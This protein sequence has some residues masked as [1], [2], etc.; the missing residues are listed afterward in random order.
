MTLLF[1]V[2]TIHVPKLNSHLVW[3]VRE[4]SVGRFFQLIM[5]I[6]LGVTCNLNARRIGKQWNKIFGDQRT[7][8]VNLIA[9]EIKH[10]FFF[11]EYRYMT[12]S[13]FTHTIYVINSKSPMQDNQYAR[14]IGIPTN[15]LETNT[16]WNILDWQNRQNDFEKLAFRLKSTEVRRKWYTIMAKWGHLCHTLN[17]K[18]VTSTI[19]TKTPM[20]ILCAGRVFASAIISKLRKFHMPK[21]F[22]VRI[23]VQMCSYF[24]TSSAKRGQGERKKG[25]RERVEN[26][27]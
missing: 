10:L 24:V 8:D 19:F 9:F 23:R 13:S 5:V 25:R 16:W 6:F 14:F 15:R 2:K 4:K 3:C 11:C 20:L 1:R 21:A 17:P 22:Y 7:V 26:R 27:I 12:I 18:W